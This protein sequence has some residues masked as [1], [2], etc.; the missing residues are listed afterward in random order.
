MHQVICTQKKHRLSGRRSLLTR[1]I[2][3]ALLLSLVGVVSAQAPAA[4]DAEDKADAKNLGEITVTARKRAE[5]LREVP[6]AVT[7]FSARQIEE[8]AVDDLGELDAQVPNLT[9][10]S[11]RGSSSTVTAYLRGV[12]QSDP[13]WG[14]DP[15]VGIYL[16]DVY[17]ARPQGALL[18]ILDVA[19]IE[20]LRGPQGTLYGKNTTGGAIKYIT[21]PLAPEFKASGSITIGEYNQLD[22]KA[23]INAPLGESV[24]VRLSV[25]SF[26]RDGFGENIVT[27]APVSDKEILVGRLSIGGAI[28]DQLNVVF[29]A[30]WLDD[31]SGVR[32]AQRL[33]PFNSFDPLRRPPLDSRYDVANDLPNI[34]DTS[35]DGVS[36]TAEYTLDAA[37]SFKSITARRSSDTDTY[38]DFDLL[39]R[40]ITNVRATYRDEQLSQEFQLNYAGNAL[41]GVL[42]FFYFDGEAGGTVFNN[43]INASFGTTNGTVFTR[44][45][46]FYGEGSYAISE[47]LSITAGL[48]YTRENKEAEVLNQAF[49]NPDFTSVLATPADFTD[50]EDFNNLSPKL[51]LDY[52]FSDDTLL[53]GLVSKG[54]KSGGFNIRANVAAVPRSAR[55]FEDES[56][57][58]FELGTKTAFA[59][60]RLFLNAAIFH[61]TYKDVQLSVF[62]AFDS[63]GD[64]TNDAFFGDFTNAGKGTIRGAELELAAQPTPAWNINGQVGYLNAR[65]DEFIDRG[66]NI[67]S[68]QRFTNAPRLSASLSTQYTWPA[69]G[70]ELSARVAS[71]YQSKV[72]P[73]TDLSEAIA[74]SGYSLLN[75]GLI[76]RNNEHWTVSLQGSNLTDKEYRTT[77]YNI[78]VFGILTGFY[79]APRQVSLMAK[80]DF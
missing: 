48:R 66:V 65:Y 41:T 24:A 21:A 17:L 35:L 56:V 34:N 32:G 7:A 23:S 47:Q 42:G 79:G 25:G 44:S 8:A 12:G 39:P 67:A 28:S 14:V 59:D 74:Q 70:G 19:R 9:I 68:R 46:A 63:N 53:Y 5:T 54:Y 18:D 55:P 61:N 27:G 15:G 43:F 11:A 49:R 36:L 6:V 80:Y 40:P 37:W 26:T 50:D 76:W 57:T 1:S 58:S 64:G 38:I 71:S 72:Y 77:G 22:T 51:S 78:G 4:E 73:T 31:Q 69:F 45:N 75:A 30:D 33:N 3:S 20:V 60:N 2:T 16:D 52:T 13:L 29:S 62:T 10:Y